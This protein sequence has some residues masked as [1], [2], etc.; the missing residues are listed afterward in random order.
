[1]M[2]PLFGNP[3]RI[4]LIVITLFIVFG[5][6]AASDGQAATRVVQLFYFLPNDQTY[7]PSIVDRWRHTDT[8]PKRSR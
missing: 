1:M 2:K 4:V 6:L 8:V 7:S 5:T 3:K